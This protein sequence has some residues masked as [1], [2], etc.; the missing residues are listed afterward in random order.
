M[1][2]SLRRVTR[3]GIRRGSGKQQKAV[4]AG[5]QAIPVSTIASS[6]VE[7]WRTGIP[8]AW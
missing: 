4:S 7:N 5:L 8:I 2:Q 3:R 6:A 1:F